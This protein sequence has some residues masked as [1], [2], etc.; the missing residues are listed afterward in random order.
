LMSKF[1]KIIYIHLV[2][3]LLVIKFKFLEK[4]RS[5][6]FSVYWHAQTEKTKEFSCTGK[7]LP[8]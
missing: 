1:V 3:W 2:W 8:L 7:F 4:K 5:W 6:S